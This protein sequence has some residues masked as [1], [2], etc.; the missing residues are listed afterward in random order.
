MCEHCFNSADLELPSG[1]QLC[2]QCF[3][4]LYCRLC[5][6]HTNLVGERIHLNG[7]DVCAGC[8]NNAPPQPVEPY[9]ETEFDIYDN[10][11]E[12]INHDGTFDIPLIYEYMTQNNATIDEDWP[13]APIETDEADD[14][15]DDETDD[16]TD[17]TDNGPLLALPANFDMNAASLIEQNPDYMNNMINAQVEFDGIWYFVL[18]NQIYSVPYEIEIDDDYV[19]RDIRNNWEGVQWRGTIFGEY[20]AWY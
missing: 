13:V 15:A 10:D 1:V 5:W 20:I 4:E 19:R 16:D 6:R 14:E 12:I 8:A 7:I 11:P 9:E 2:G 18:N 3:N 17:D